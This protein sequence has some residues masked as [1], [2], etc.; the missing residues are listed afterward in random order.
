M[1]T[2]PPSCVADAP[3]PVQVT[4][5]P[6]QAPECA[7]TCRDAHPDPGYFLR[8]SG[9]RP[10][11]RARAGGHGRDGLPHRAAKAG[12]C[13][14]WGARSPGK[15]GAGAPD[16][17]PSLGPQGSC[18]VPTYLCAAG[19]ASPADAWAL[20]GQLWAVRPALC[21]S[22]GPGQRS[23]ARA[24]RVP[25]G[26]GELGCRCPRPAGPP[27]AGLG[28]PVFEGSCESPHPP[29]LPSHTPSPG[30]LSRRSRPLQNAKHVL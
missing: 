26:L 27:G 8:A 7:A 11:Q 22:Q 24:R 15:G 12:R 25:A 16:P 1:P 5:E 9:A 10:G 6:P 2:G 4:V 20:G 17:L 18:P 23:P 14:A 28:S 19:S 30:R 21:G 29:P 13:P 3:A